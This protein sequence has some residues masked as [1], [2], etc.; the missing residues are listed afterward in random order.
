M[1]ND[2]SEEIDM[3]VLP[4]MW[5]EDINE[6]RKQFN[7]EKPGADHDMLE[8]VK[9]KEETAAVDFNRLVDLTTYSE[10][11]SSQLSNL[12]K[13]WEYKQANA[14][15]LLREELDNL[16]KQQKKVELK[17]LEMI[18]EHRFEEHKYGGNK[19]PVSVSDEVYDIWQEVPRR[20]NDVVVHDQRPEVEAEYDTVIFWKQRA[21]HLEKLLEASMQR[22][23][24]ALEKLQE[25]IHNLERQSSPVEEL[26]QVLRRAD[27]YLHFVLQNAPVVFGHQVTLSSNKFR[28]LVQLC[29]K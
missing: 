27:N 24:I 26:S 14:V 4:S 25:S 29:N 28:I 3:E 5:P 6:E 11:G 7:L 21:I 19:R 15:R 9:L 8:G 2:H 12:V 18:E 16:S 10:K 22:E 13:S 23:Q 17:K 1:E 20:R